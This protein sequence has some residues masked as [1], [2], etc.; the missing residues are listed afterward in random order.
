MIKEPDAVRVLDIIVLWEDMWKS[1]TWT[2]DTDQHSW[3]DEALRITW[4]DN[5][6]ILIGVYR[7][8]GD[9]LHAVI[10][11]GKPAYFK[12]HYDEYGTNTSQPW[13]ALDDLNGDGK[14]TPTEQVHWEIEY[15]LITGT[16]TQYEAPWGAV[17][18]IWK[19]T[20]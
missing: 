2:D 5:G 20:P 18:T 13:M 1:P 6:S 3:V 10:I 11:A 4:L 16:I 8:S 7:A 17:V 14:I 9:W 12:P 19:I 15:D